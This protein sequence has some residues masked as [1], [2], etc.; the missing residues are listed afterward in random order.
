MIGVY[1][2]DDHKMVI[3]GMQLLLQDDP[4]IQVVGFATDGEEALEKIS[5]ETADV[6]LLD[7]NM[8]GINGID[9]CKA[10]LKKHQLLL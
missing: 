3:E 5:S 8:P 6:V 2:V 1:I 7:I 4:D 10:L 9:T